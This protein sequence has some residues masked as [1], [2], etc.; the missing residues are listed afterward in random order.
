VFYKVVNVCYSVGTL[1]VS[2]IV[3]SL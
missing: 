3:I 2:F 1:K